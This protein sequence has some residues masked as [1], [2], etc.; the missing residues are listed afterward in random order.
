METKYEEL[1]LTETKN[2][3]NQTTSTSETFTTTALPTILSTI[4]TSTVS[5]TTMTS[6]TTRRNISSKPSST[7]LS[8]T[9]GTSSVTDATTL[10]TTEASRE[11]FEDTT[12]NSEAEHDHDLKSKYVKLVEHNS[13]LVD[14][15]KT[16]MQIQTDMSRKLIHYVFP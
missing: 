13:K 14:L 3:D 2:S 5:T 4:K 9:T 8:T 11:D 16:T 12:Q 7:T 10:P 15:L 6:P 1:P